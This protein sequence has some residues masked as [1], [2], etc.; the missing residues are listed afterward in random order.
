MITIRSTEPKQPIPPLM[1]IREV[2]KLLNVSRHT[3]HALIDRGDLVAS[4]V[5]STKTK[6]LHRRVTRHSLLRF[7]KKRFGQVLH[8]DLENPFAPQ[9]S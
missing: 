3:V 9:K 6:R 4:N 1:K 5:N 7:Y 8:D 2:A